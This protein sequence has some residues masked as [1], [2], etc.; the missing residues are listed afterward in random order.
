MKDELAK[1]IDH[2]HSLGAEYVEVRAQQLFKTLLTTKDGRVEGAKEG[3]ES[4]VGIRAL[5]KGAWGFVSLG[6]L[7]SK[8]LTEAVGDAVRLAKAA[9]SKVK[10]PVKLSDANLVL[11][12]SRHFVNEVCPLQK[13]A[14]F[15]PM[16]M[17]LTKYHEG[18][19]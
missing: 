2:G 10:S 5:V 9:S 8:P 11:A 3:T 16:K 17:Y 13:L 6:K 15:L 18:L 7:E 19:S 14:D 1:T 12:S 4:G